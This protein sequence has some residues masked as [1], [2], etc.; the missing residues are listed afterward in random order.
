MPD[1][2]I[3]SSIGSMDFG[4]STTGGLRNIRPDRA[5]IVRNEALKNEARSL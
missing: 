3:S 4:T 5:E 1:M 2:V